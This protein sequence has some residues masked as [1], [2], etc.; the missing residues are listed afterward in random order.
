MGADT[1]S[2]P[3][4]SHVWCLAGEIDALG[5]T[6]RVAINATPFRVGRG[7]DVP[8][9]LPCL[10]V[11]K[12]H[13]ELTRHASDL[14]VR[15]LQSTNGTYINGQ[16]IRLEQAL[17]EGDLLQFGNVVFQVGC[18]APPAATGTIGFGTANRAE[19]IRQFDRLMRDR[20]VLAFFQPIVCMSS[21]KTVGYEV[22][23]RSSLLGLD[24][25]Q[26]MFQAAS[27]LKVEAELSQILR[28]EGIQ[29]SIGLQG[30]P[31]LFLNTHPVELDKPGLLESLAAI[32]ASNPDLSITLEIHEAMVTH[33]VAMAELRAAL[34]DLQ[35]HLAYD[36]FGAGQSRLLELFAVP[37][38]YLKF[39]M[40]IVQGIHRASDQR[41]SMLSSLIAMVRD[42]GII[43]LAE[44]IECEADSTTCSQLGFELAQGFYFGRPALAKDCSAKGP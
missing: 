21:H 39:D 31:N 30:K 10:S 38:D 27:V 41:Q 25:P 14:C 40:S 19:Q 7:P 37:P 2:L 3:L 32:R 36:D 24:T 26:A 18:E 20:D 1:K 23:G 11:S 17:K 29:S 28:L 4:N 33:P 16:R 34:C 13:A 43:P 6:R 42:A 8:L 9:S 35:I 12:L 44:G 5:S 22:L 15:D